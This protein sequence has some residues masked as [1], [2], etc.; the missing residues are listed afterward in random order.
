M[1]I[2]RQ[3]LT[4]AQLELA[5]CPDA[6]IRFKDYDAFLSQ[7]A[8]VNSI[9]FIQAR[10][11]GLDMD[12]HKT[13]V[14]PKELSLDPKV[15]QKLGP[16]LATAKEGWLAPR[17]RTAEAK[18]FLNAVYSCLPEQGGVAA[19]TREGCEERIG[20]R[21]FVDGGT[22]MGFGRLREAYPV[23]GVIPAKPVSAEEAAEA[24]VGCGLSLRELPADLLVPYPLLP[25][26]EE[27]F[28]TRVNPHAENGFPVGGTWSTEGAPQ[29]IATL[30]VRMRELLEDAYQ[31]EGGIWTFVREAEEANPHLVALKCKAK[32]DY[33]S[34]SKIENFGLRL[35]YVVG[36]HLVFNMQVASR[37]LE[38]LSRSIFMEG[39][40]AQGITLTRGGAEKLVS[41][42]DEQL[43]EGGKAFVHCGD[44]TWLA[45]RAGGQVVL[46]SLDCSSFDLTQHA[47][48]T[49]QI[50]LA[51]R[52]ELRL[53]D[54]VAADL[55][56]AIARE[57]VVVTAGTVVRR[58]KHGGASG[59]VLQSKVNDLLMHVLVRRIMSGLGRVDLTS[60]EVLEEHVKNQ[61][62]M[63]GL[64]VRLE[65]HYVVPAGSLREAVTKQPFLFLGYYFHERDGHIV[66]CCD[67]PRSLAQ[68][69]YPSV[70]WEKDKNLLEVR[71]VMR[72]ASTVMNWGIP[73][74]ELV[75]AFNTARQHLVARLEQVLARHGEAD[76]DKLKWA[77][78]GDVFGPKPEATLSGLLR[79]MER[80]PRQLWYPEAPVAGPSYT[81]SWAD[82]VEAAEEE[83]VL[84]FIGRPYVRPPSRPYAREPMVLRLYR[85]TTHP[86]T[87]ANDG[88]PPPSARWLPDKPPRPAG[89]RLRRA[90]MTV[91]SASGGWQID[92]SYA[93]DDSTEYEPSEA[94]STSG[95]WGRDSD[96]EDE[97]WEEWDF[98]KQGERQVRQKTTE[99]Q[100]ETEE[101]S[102]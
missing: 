58:W 86:V 14:L 36:R 56:F 100:P 52:E 54:P 95:F 87:L 5:V 97:Q 22:Q 70:K 21:F 61:G 69:Q 64:K 77:V 63:M 34:S 47:T 46:F 41:K 57:R 90:G 96:D 35:Y 79:A 43:N 31:R 3:A 93:G 9:E 82:Q 83:R 102:D 38:G 101:W 80:D 67:L 20:D 39:Y 49:E 89:P 24:M 12:L 1:Q 13:V 37:V 51:L 81:M 94:P 10:L 26:E 75:P 6:F 84:A 62:R 55:W 27:G 73:P 85:P 30:A 88:R 29:R 40:S 16:A 7:K 92:E 99:E 72:L 33:Y 53:V 98:F 44:D 19:F 45:A 32:S 50:H 76:S 28:Q 60:R 17:I 18:R 2:N 59:M 68:M 23:K 8:S 65:D 74:V 11:A 71:E 15:L 66:V 25:V 42:L 4:K 91:F 78:Y 48:V